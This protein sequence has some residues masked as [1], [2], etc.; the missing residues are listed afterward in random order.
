MA[1]VAKWKL[2]E[3]E[4]LGNLLKEYPVVGVVDMGGMPARQLQRMR[5]QL[6]GEVLIKMS[7]KSLMQHAIEKASKEEKSLQSLGEHIKGQPAFI[8]SKINP[9][10][11]NRILEKN[12]ASA[13]AK[14]NAI[15]PKDILIKKGETPLPPGPLVGE[16]QQVG[17]PAAI[18][19]GKITIK[20]DCIVVREGERISPKLAAILTR[21]NIEPMEIGLNLLA[22]YEKGTIF[23]P[24][25]LSIDKGKVISDLQEAFRG[26]MNLSANSG[27]VT[28]ET[29]SLVISKAF[30]EAKTLAIQANIPEP[31]V[32]GDI[33]AKASLQ[34]LSLAS[35]LDEEALDEDLRENIRAKPLGEKLGE[36]PKEKVEEKAEEKEEEKTEEEAAEGLSALFG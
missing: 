19:G 14:P 16:M 10:K 32:M 4:S 35:L 31:S 18:A 17:I 30:R 9:F 15:A 28:K 21:L 5:A 26:A 23:L 27:F 1:K 7:K 2:E 34:M 36:K 29:A 24:D 3:V 25:V 13:P 11:L 8:F 33:V 12:R 6:R 22:A 20:E